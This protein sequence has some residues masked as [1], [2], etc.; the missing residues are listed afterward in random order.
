MVSELSV[1]EQPEQ[2]IH[3]FCTCEVGLHMYISNYTDLVG[4]HI[5]LF[6]HNTFCYITITRARPRSL[7]GTFKLQPFFSWCFFVCYFDF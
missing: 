2:D 1:V 6:P 7:S 3:N 5:S 4:L